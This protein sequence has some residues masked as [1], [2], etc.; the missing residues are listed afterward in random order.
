MKAEFDAVEGE[1]TEIQLESEHSL[2]K[3]AAMANLRTFVDRVEKL[4]DRL[5]AE[6]GNT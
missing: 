2:D 4:I 6:L 5:K 3:H 1:W